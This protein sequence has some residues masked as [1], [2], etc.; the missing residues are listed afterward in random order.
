MISR[1]PTTTTT[2][3]TN[4]TNREDADTL[5]AC[6]S[7]FGFLFLAFSPCFASSFV[8]SLPFRLFLS[9]GSFSDLWGS[10]VG[11]RMLLNARNVLSPQIRVDAS[12]HAMTNANLK[13]LHHQ[14][15]KGVVSR[16]EKSWRQKRPRWVEFQTA[17][18]LIIMILYTTTVWDEPHFPAIHQT[19]KVMSEPW[20]WFIQ[21]SPFS[22]LCAYS[23]GMM[24]YTI[25]SMDPTMTWQPHKHYCNYGYIFL[26]S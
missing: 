4:T 1:H 19:N 24:D 25:T 17:V 5:A 15:Q 7:F 21:L 8:G 11:T 3:T 20:F 12:N 26:G 16:R 2:T 14:K 18:L 23:Y 9:R 22:S 6:S 10:A 13:A